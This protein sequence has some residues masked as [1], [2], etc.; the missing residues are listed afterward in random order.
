MST[1][2]RTEIVASTGPVMEAHSKPMNAWQ[3]ARPTL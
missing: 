1:L 3:T 2:A